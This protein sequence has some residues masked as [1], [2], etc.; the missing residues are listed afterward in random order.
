MDVHDYSVM[1]ARWYAAFPTLPTTSGEDLTDKVVS[2]DGRR[3]ENCTINGGTRLIYE[4]EKPFVFDCKLAVKPNGR[5]IEVSSDNPAIQQ[6]LALN[7]NFE[8]YTG[9]GIPICQSPEKMSGLQLP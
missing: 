7:H 1:Q 8:L 2:L 5:P 3:F 4:G 9:G 6:M